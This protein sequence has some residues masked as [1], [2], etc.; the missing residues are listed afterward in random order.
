VFT[1]WLDAQTPAFRD[2]IEVVAIDGFTGFK[3]GRRRA[4]PLPA[5]SPTGDLRTPWMIR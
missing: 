2:G 4:R 3:T 1:S 5:T